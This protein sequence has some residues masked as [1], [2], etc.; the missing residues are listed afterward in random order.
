MAKNPTRNML[1]HNNRGFA[2][3]REA[4]PCVAFASRVY[5]FDTCN[6]ASVATRSLMECLA[7]WG[8][9]AVAMTGTAVD[10]GKEPV[11]GNWL[12]GQ[13]LAPQ[14]F[15]GPAD[16]ANGIVPNLNASHHYRLT[17]AGVQ[18]VLD[19]SPTTHSHVPEEPEI[20]G[21]SGL[22]EGVLD[23]FRPDVLVHVVGDSL[24]EEIRRCARES[25]IA[26]VLALHDFHF[27][28]SA[29]LQDLDAVI[30]PSQFAASYYR[31]ILGLSCDVLPWPISIDR[32]RAR[33]REPRFVTFVDPTYEKGVFAFARI[34]DELGR[35]RPDIPLLVVEGSGTERTLVDCGLDLR[36]HGNVSLMPHTPDHR[37]FWGVTRICVMPSLRWESQPLV[38]VEAMI[39][40]VPVVGSDRGGMPEALGDSGI[41]LGLPSR[42]GPATREL[43]TAEEVEPWV[44]AIIALW[45]D[46]EWYSELSHR[47]IVESNRWSPEVLGPRYVEFFEG[48]RKRQQGAVG[49]QSG[50]VSV[51]ISDGGLALEPRAAA[52][53]MRSRSEFGAFLNRRGLLGTGAEIGVENGAF[54]RCVLDLWRGERMYL[55]DIWQKLEDYWDVTNAPTAEQA[56][57]M[58][59]TVRNV[60]PFWEKVRVIQER[61]ERAARLFDDNSLDWIY[62]DANHEYA[63]VLRDLAAWVPKVKA[64]GVVAGHDFID[65]VLTIG[66]VPTVI[67]V[68]RAVREFFA[69]QEVFTTEDRYPTWYLIKA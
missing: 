19:R 23:E 14:F 9:P 53:E 34:A 35:R 52:S 56:A 41:V 49:E 59:R 16:P 58:I 44:K 46:G 66:G 62:L 31:R 29:A 33:S 20:L 24:A 38:A 50:P 40:G 17:A 12:A 67:G 64:G 1:E 51:S 3:N 68:K 54:A 48:L 37:V 26:I 10:T 45:D 13:G 2:D 28:S 25:G 6:E 60:S 43:P 27:R 61:S 21:F 30:V 63:H 55:V 32:S 36:A 18:V 47:A 15:D 69:G 42:L 11:P 5:Y 4:K 65:D 8:F 39:N 7:A 57:R 22:L